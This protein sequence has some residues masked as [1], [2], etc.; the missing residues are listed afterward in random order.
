MSRFS[1]IV[2]CLG[3]AIAMV[4]CALSMYDYITFSWLHK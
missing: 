4:G 2:V 1:R 3:A